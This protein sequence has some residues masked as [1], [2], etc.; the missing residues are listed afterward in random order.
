MSMVK[1]KGFPEVGEFVLCRISRIN[2]NS[3][4]AALEEYGMEGMVHISEVSAGWVR[5]IRKFV[6]PNEL[7]VAKVVRI[8]DQGRIS[9][10][11]KRVSKN[12]ENRR[13]KSFRLEHRAEKMLEL[14]AQL[15]KKSPEETEEVGFKLQEFGSLYDAF[16]AA[17]QRPDSLVKKGVPERWVSALKEIAEKNIEQKEFEFKANLTLKTFKPNGVYIIKT[18]LAEAEKMNL[19]VRYIA[20]PNYLVKYKSKNAKKGEREFLEKLGKL[21]EHKEAELSFVMA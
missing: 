10:S 14:A 20:A 5:D 7:R 1:K 19:D 8:D 4:F 2:P 6:K 11:L 21:A 18:I 9:L 17:L 3:A 16:L 15:L 13:M 12:D